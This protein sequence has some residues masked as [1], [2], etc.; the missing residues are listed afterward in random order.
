MLVYPGVVS[1]SGDLAS[2]FGAPDEKLDSKFS[3]DDSLNEL[4]VIKH[5]PDS[6]TNFG[7][8]EATLNFPSSTWPT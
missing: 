2:K 3:D 5:H 7:I 6:A 8:L 1:E 4:N